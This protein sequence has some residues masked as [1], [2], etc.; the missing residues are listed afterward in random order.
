MT[1]VLVL[2]GTR[3]WGTPPIAASVRTWASIQSGSACVQPAWATR[4]SKRDSVPVFLGRLTGEMRK[5][6]IFVA[7][8]D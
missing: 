7:E 1:A 2:S 6:Q 4:S 3:S 8:I 5:A